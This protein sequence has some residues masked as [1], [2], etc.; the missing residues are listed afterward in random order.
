[1]LRVLQISNYMYPHLGGIEQVARD[2]AGVLT[3]LGVEQK[4]ICFN[5]TA[6]E[7]RAVCR[8]EETVHDTLDGV[9]VIRCGCVAKIASQSI[10][11]TFGREL[12]RVMDSF[13]PNV[14]IFHYPNP[15]QAHYLL[16]Y[17]KRD[18]KLILYWHLDITKQK[19]LGKF[20]HFQNLSVIRRANKILGATPMHVEQS[21]YTPYFQGKQE[22]LPYVIDERRLV[23]SKQE[24]I[25]GEALRA[26][27]PGKIVCFFIGRH[28]PYK[29]LTHLI[30]A[31]SLLTDKVHFYIAGDGPLTDSLKVQAANDEKV[32]FVGRLTD[33][34][35]RTYLYACDIFCF[36]SIT[37]NEG[38]GLALAEA[39]YFGKPAVTFTIPGSGV[40]YVN[41]DGVT[42]IECPNRDANAYAA[43]IEKLVSSPE[44]RE[45]MGRHARER[46]L[47]NF[48]IRQFQGNIRRML[49]ELYEDRDLFQLPF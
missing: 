18:F 10:S 31:S 26:Q 35:Y 44:L 25:I 16:R 7:G 21:A 36:P 49:E 48:T 11:M 20:F 9:E 22:I 45:T 43:A 5:E 41:L 30:Q 46:V 24:K 8:R 39:M 28:V 12:N 14:V 4:I 3:Q 29:G 23:L 40:N 37:R 38:F 33:S 42:G 19:I 17:R 13:R 32:K 47:E 6:S 34:Q 2:I 1:M 27:H 15:F